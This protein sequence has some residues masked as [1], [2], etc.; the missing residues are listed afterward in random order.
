V[1][2]S[3]AGA[4]TLSAGNLLTT[5][6]VPAPSMDSH[7][8]EP[9]Q[10]GHGGT[11]PYRCQRRVGHPPQSHH[12]SAQPR[13]RT[14]IAHSFVWTKTAD[15]ILTKAKRPTTATQATSHPPILR[16]Q[17]R[18][19]GR[20]W[21][22][23]ARVAGRDARQLEDRAPGRAVEGDREA[24]PRPGDRPGG[25]RQSDAPCAARRGDRGAAPR[26]GQPVGAGPRR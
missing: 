13:P 23:R 2:L 11:P 4:A 25:S 22:V 1:P 24:A 3:D 9:F 14:D 18:I 6:R 16:L 19:S 7:R 20:T 17:R 26:R 8:P 21:A 12:R 10:P 15:Q 5:S